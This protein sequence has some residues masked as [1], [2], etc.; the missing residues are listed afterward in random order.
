MKRKNLLLLLL[1]C[2]GPLLMSANDSGF[3]N[4][5]RAS[6]K[7][8][9]VYAVIAVILLGLFIYLFIL[10]RKVKKLEDRFRDQ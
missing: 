2:F 8:Y 10:D 3:E 4:T 9:V 6:G 5:M 1:A 7:I